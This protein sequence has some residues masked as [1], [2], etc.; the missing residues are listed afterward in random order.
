MKHWQKFEPYLLKY[1]LAAI[2]LFQILYPKFP[3]IGVTGT[4]VSVRLEDLLLAVITGVYL[5]W[6]LGHRREL[7]VLGSTGIA[8]ILFF[9]I[10]F[11]STL[12]AILVIH[13]VVPHLGILH[14][15]RRIEYLIT[16]FIA[17][18]IIRKEKDLL[19]FVELIFWA[20]V[21]VL[22]YGLGQKYL[23]FPV[24][25]TQNIEFAKGLLLTLTPGARLNSTFAGHYDL[26]AF[27]VLTL[28]LFLAL[29][30]SPVNKYFKFLGFAGFLSNFW[31]LLASSSRISFPAYLVSIL[32]LLLIT[33]RFKLIPV[34]LVFS[35]T[36]M[37]SSTELASRYLRTID[38]YLKPLSSLLNISHKPPTEPPYTLEEEEPEILPEVTSPPVAVLPGQP[39]STPIPTPTRKPKIKHSITPTPPPPPVIVEERSTEIRLNA[40]W[41]RAVRAFKKHPLLGTGY[42]SITLATDNDYLRLLGEVGALGAFTFALVFISLAKQSL[43]LFKQKHQS[44]TKILGF[45]LTAGLIG[46]LINATFIDVFEASKVA[47]LF[48]AMAGTLLALTQIEKS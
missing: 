29:W 25:S 11:L 40:E 45:G 7:K 1:G 3:L 26:A 47:P 5:V 8:I 35:L 21:C 44:A 32:L 43:Y 17:A 24:V 19:F 41:P 42:S 22:L 30:L 39:V 2:I 28:P 37:L 38:V 23:E 13:T 12:T 27:T 46:F 10:G 16:F 48:W 18:T 33:R 31:L 20:S 34:L 6:A 9:C 14:F 4:Y 36:F 15:L